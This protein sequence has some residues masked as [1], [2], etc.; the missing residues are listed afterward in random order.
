MWKAVKSVCKAWYA[1]GKFIGVAMMS[2]VTATAIF[3]LVLQI[4]E[5]HNEK[6]ECKSGCLPWEIGR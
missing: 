2:L 4:I 5:R 3:A 1:F 6:K